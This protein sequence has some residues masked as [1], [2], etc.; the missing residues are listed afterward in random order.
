MALS[1]AVALWYIVCSDIN[2][3]IRGERDVSSRARSGA[4]QLFDCLIS[5][6]VKLPAVCPSLVDGGMHR[7]LGIVS[8]VGIMKTVRIGTAV[9]CSYQRCRFFLTR[10]PV[11][12]EF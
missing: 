4:K 11:N 9:V 8:M 3:R 2:I 5:A 1:T 10:V 12:E 7:C 6:L